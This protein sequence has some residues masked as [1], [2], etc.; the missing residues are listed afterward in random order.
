MGFKP[1]THQGSE[2]WSLGR[3][4]QP[5]QSIE[6]EMT[7]GTSV[8]G[9]DS[10]YNPEVPYDISET[11]RTICSGIPSREAPSPRILSNGYATSKSPIG[12]LGRVFGPLADPYRTGLRP[13]LGS[14]ANSSQE[15]SCLLPIEGSMTLSPSF[16]LR[17]RDEEAYH[18]K[19]RRSRVILSPCVEARGLP[20]NQC[21]GK[22]VD[23]INKQTQ[24][25]GGCLCT[26]ATAELRAIDRS[27]KSAKGNIK[28]YKDLEGVTTPLR[29]RGLH[30]TECAR[31][32]PSK[33]NIPPF[34]D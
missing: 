29:P 34:K 14:L 22:I 3:V 18:Q 19:S 15:T 33:T 16:S 28:T 5:P 26:Q 2:V 20:L 11:R 32:H 1:F 9:R 8:Y 23:S 21:C 12:I 10:G 7:M 24:G 27:T 13:P 17:K 4:R 30:P 25:H 6:S 31:V